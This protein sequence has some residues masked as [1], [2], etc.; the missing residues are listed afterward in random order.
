M[1]LY[2]IESTGMDYSMFGWII[3]AYF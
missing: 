1:Y 2:A 3:N